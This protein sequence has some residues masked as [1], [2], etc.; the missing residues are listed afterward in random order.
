MNKGKPAAGG[1]FSDV[2]F[3]QSSRQNQNGGK[4][5][6]R[7]QNSGKFGSNDNA[8]RNGNNNQ[9][10]PGVAVNRM[11]GRGRSDT[12]NS[13][14]KFSKKGG[15]NELNRNTNSISLK[16]NNNSRTN[17]ANNS[18]STNGANNI[19]SI[20]KQNLQNSTSKKNGSNIPE[21]PKTKNAESVRPIKV[22]NG[23]S[24]DSNSF[25]VKFFGTL[26]QN[27]E[28]LRFQKV[29]HRPKK[30]PRYMLKENVL[31]DMSSFQ[32][33]QWDYQNQQMLLK[34]ESEF[35]GEPQLLFEEFQEHRKVERDQMEKYNLVDKENA[36]KS[37]DDAIIF[38][39][40]CQDMCPTYERVERVFK[41][42][43][44]KW[45]KDPI[46]GKISRALAIKTFMRPSGQAPPLPSDVRPP[47]VLQK[48]LDHIIDTLL[49]KLP[50]SQ[51][52]IWDRTRSIRQDF[53]F[54]NNYS[55]IESIDCH[56]KICRIHII[57]LHVMAGANDPD[58]QQQQEVEQFNNSLQTLTHMYDDVRSRGGFCPNESEFR[59]YE[60]LSKI[61]DTELDRYLQ[62]LPDYVQ[63]APIVQR[64]IMLRNLIIQG[65]NNLNCYFEFFKIILDKSKTT[66]LLAS[67]AEIHF[68][69]IRFNALRMMGRSY[70]SKSKKM[71]LITDTSF[72][73][74]YND[75]DQFVETC[76]LYSLPVFHDDETGLS[77]V[78]VSALKSAFKVSQKQPYTNR[79]DDMINGLSMSAIVKGTIVNEHLDLKK[80]QTLEQ[81]ARE[82]FKGSKQNSLSVSEIFANNKKVQ[83]STHHV[84]NVQPFKQDHEKDIMTPKFDNQNNLIT[85]IGNANNSA[86]H[87]FSLQQVKD[88]GFSQVSN[89]MFAE[90]PHI[91]DKHNFS[92]NT[93]AQVVQN[94]KP[95]IQSEMSTE[96]RASTS[97]SEKAFTQSDRGP[98]LQPGSTEIFSQRKLVEN[99]LFK[100]G[101]AKYT[102][103]MVVDFVTNL[104]KGMINQKIE[105]EKTRRANESRKQ[106]LCE[107]SEEMFIAFMKEQ[108][109][110]TLLDARAVTFYKRTLKIRILKHVIQTA[111]IA[112]Q[113]KMANEA[114]THEIEAFNASITM[115][116]IFPK[117]PVTVQK[118][119][120][121][122]PKFSTTS[123]NI[124][125]IFNNV[126]PT[127][128]LKGII[129]LR[130]PLSNTSNWILGQLGFQDGK[131][132]MNIKS[133]NGHNLALKVL[134]DTFE[135]QNYFENTS[136]IIIQV[137]TIESVDNSTRSSL[138]EC[139]SRDAKVIA[140]LK[141][142][143]RRFSSSS[144]FSIMII[145]VDVFGINLTYAEIKDILC[146]E[147]LSSSGIILGFFKLDGSFL[148][149]NNSLSAAKR[150]QQ[151]FSKLLKTVW[152]KL[153]SK[154][155]DNCLDL[156]SI[157][158]PISRNISDTTTDPPEITPNKLH[159]SKSVIFPSEIIK[160]RVKYLHRMI[161]DSKTKRRKYSNSSR[162]SEL[163]SYLTNS[164]QDC[165]PD[166]TREH[167]KLISTNNSMF[168]TGGKFSGI[169]CFNNSLMMLRNYQNA[170]KAAIGGSGANSDDKAMQRMQDI[171]ELDQLA[172][173]ILKK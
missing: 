99:P 132:E 22:G 67:L 118:L 95:I 79:I 42:Q 74:G 33:N 107:L 121:Q 21:K 78:D 147:D 167:S 108:I 128:D 70:H 76:K 172:D 103:K 104:G 86:G 3:F 157:V 65:M 150:L 39:G 90:K 152:G 165:G 43:V 18:G 115:P 19:R 170:N 126:H 23:F 52:F 26:L 125:N 11:K 130:C 123:S 50:E 101:V 114:T 127:F 4:N 37:L 54:Q 58:Y 164:F 112:L 32:P 89:Q 151:D 166:Y 2:N 13:T 75:A 158:N 98:K 102:D 106:L 41:N 131:Q 48:T 46:T 29:S 119:K 134:P 149:V 91:H 16:K 137:G 116:V 82:S 171:S 142:Y 12:K 7:F 96:H 24:T 84:L 77:R 9:S 71:P 36:K 111:K 55:G 62:T 80:P 153:Y 100:D 173:S 25:E 154:S 161:D 66:F 110:F 143:L 169:N 51:S 15:N 20:K 141:D 64:T 97:E 63:N 120:S 85:S 49:P 138:L 47:N 129:V 73:L 133:E 159:D 162:H 14:S 146:L 93:V 160:K 136:T 53:T 1:N 61:K 35:A 72:A 92:G 87:A 38:R 155:G 105:E 6:L 163:E 109:Y 45:E 8:V 40:S 31:F 27:P 57:S 83:L 68:N 56:E 88:P 156:R 34:R 113:K 5:N 117:M 60:L 145:Y 135:A 30:I 168:N 10:N 124:K 148:R 122:V 81:I 59:A 28:A 139:L 94:V 69:E 44:S 140:K 144:R 17:A